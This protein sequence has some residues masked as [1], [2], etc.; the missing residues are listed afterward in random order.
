[1]VGLWLLIKV[2]RVFGL[3]LAP[4]DHP[5]VLLLSNLRERCPKPQDRMKDEDEG[6]IEVGAGTRV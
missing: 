6:E 3:T 1:M 4:G 2:G 5:A